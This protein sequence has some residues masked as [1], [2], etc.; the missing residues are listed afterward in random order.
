MRTHTDG[1]TVQA[2]AAIAFLAAFSAGSREASAQWIVTNLHP[3]GPGDSYAFS[4]VGTQQGGQISPGGF[5][6]RASIWNGSAGTYMDLHPSWA[7]EV[8]RD[9]LIL[10]TSG[11]QQVGFAFYESD[12][13]TRAS[14]WSGTAASW[15][16]LHP[17]GSVE[18]YARAISG[19]QQVGYA[20]FGTV[21]HA[22][23]WSG[24]AASWVDLHPVGATASDANATTGT[25]QAGFADLGGVMRASL[26]S[27][28]AASRIDLHPAGSNASSVNAMSGNVQAGFSIM[29]GEGHA[30]LWSGSAASWVSIHPAASAWSVVYGAYGNQQV[31][32]AIIDG[33]FHASLWSGS[34]ASWVDLHAMLPGTWRDSLAHGLWSDGTTTRI[35]GY[36]FNLDTGRYEA[37][38]WTHIA[39]TCAADC[40][41]SG[42]LNIDDFICFQTLFALADPTADCDAS[43]ALN[44]DDFICFQTLFA[45][46]C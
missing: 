45:L 20:I 10:H 46:G 44:I 17:A 2:R 28:T 4:V 6:P 25:Q 27:G 34:A 38:L 13:I 11:T 41:A 26:W 42:A 8:A 12:Q 16:S 22:G 15:T 21:R 1:F 43:G 39:A 18:S 14:L 3:P 9:S 7:G 29:N 35:A 24:T 33:N 19:S 36:G 5:F 40:D 32:G 30:G 23:L 37:L 31:G